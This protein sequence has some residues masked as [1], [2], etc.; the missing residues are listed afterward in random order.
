MKNSIHFNH[1]VSRYKMSYVLI[2]GAKS[3][4]A[5][6]LAKKY[7]ENGHDLYLAARQPLELKCFANDL[8]IRSRKNVKYVFT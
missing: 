5:K 2:I 6:A 7:A 1:G 3:D 4:I 8:N